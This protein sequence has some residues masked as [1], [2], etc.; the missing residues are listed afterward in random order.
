MEK[1]E[2]RVFQLPGNR[3]PEGNHGQDRVVHIL[4]DIGKLS[5]VKVSES[6]HGRVK[7]AS[8]HD[9]R[10]AFGVRWSQRVMPPVLM[11]LM[12]HAD[13]STTMQFYVGRNAER[14]ASD[15]WTAYEQLQPP[16]NTLGNT[17]P[18]SPGGDANSE[19][20]PRLL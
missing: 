20:E 12:R 14:A 18:E 2:G 5:G 4:C 15:A 3:T 13:I 19:T 10:R 17:S 11:E 6:A 1:R 9:L 7:F 8:A 16:G